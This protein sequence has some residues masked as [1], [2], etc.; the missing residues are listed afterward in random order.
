ME[1]EPVYAKILMHFGNV[2]TL[3]VLLTFVMFAEDV[4]AV[5]CIRTKRPPFN[6]LMDVFNSAAKELL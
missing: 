5:K 4:D 3:P 6:D 2:M 1:I